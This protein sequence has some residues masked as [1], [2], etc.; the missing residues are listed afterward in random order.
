MSVTEIP[1]FVKKSYGRDVEVSDVHSGYMSSTLKLVSE[2]EFF[3][4]K[5]ASANESGRQELG[6]SFISLL[7][8]EGVPVSKC[9][10]SASGECWID[11]AQSRFSLWEFLEGDPYVPGNTDQLAEAA[12]VL[13]RIHRLGRGLAISN[14]NLDISFL[15]R[16]GEE[17]DED[18]SV[19][20]LDAKSI[21]GRTI[22]DFRSRLERI[23]EQFP[24]EMPCLGL[25]HGDFR[26]QNLL[27]RGN[28]VSGVLDFDSAHIAPRLYDVSYALMFFQAVLASEPLTDS[29]F[30]HFLDSY[31]VSF[32]IDIQNELSF[33]ALL[34]ISLL[35]GVTLWMR[36]FRETSNSRAGQWIEAYLPMLNWVDRFSQ[37]FPNQFS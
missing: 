27:F 24:T 18:W 23:R 10:P 21:T 5:V 26:G 28:K 9:I 31:C 34:E 8:S 1:E 30:F 29:E 22:H 25:I 6:M 33:P 15:D 37:E 32:G 2:S 36:I 17:L 7:A 19:L 12:S 35:K 11:L 20:E 14:V 16:L 3:I 4:L 13:G